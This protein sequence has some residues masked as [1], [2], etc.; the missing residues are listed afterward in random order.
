MTDLGPLRTAHLTI[1]RLRASDA[2]ALAAYRSDP[3]VARYQGWD[4]PVTLAD[5]ERFVEEVAGAQPLV[6]GEWYQLGIARRVDDVLVGDLGVVVDAGDPRLAR[7]G[8]TL[9]ADAQGMGYATEALAAV[10]DH[11]LV[12]HG[13]HRVSADCDT[14]NHASA[15]L[16]ARVGMRREAH[17]RRS[18]WWKGEWTDE[19][20]FAVLAQE[21]AERRS[22]DRQS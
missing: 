11:L 14:R 8:I 10:L 19:L 9:A 16:L 6:P 1:R 17:H 18:S 13:L 3:D 5:A 22:G 2:P 7:V 12:D 4:T 21:W 20:V 15:A